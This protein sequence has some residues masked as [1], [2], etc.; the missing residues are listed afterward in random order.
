MEIHP[1]FTE[2]WEEWETSTESFIS[3]DLPQWQGF[4]KESRG[5]LR[6]AGKASVKILV[7]SKWIFIFYVCTMIDN[8]MMCMYIYIY[9][10]FFQ[11]ARY[12]IN[13]FHA[14][15]RGMKRPE[16]L[17]KKKRQMDDK[18]YKQP[19]FGPPVGFQKHHLL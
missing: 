7:L 19:P 15:N 10:C 18:C 8:V 4:L 14:R 5:S 1:L 9:I 11:Y 13:V 12:N 6:N 2:P 17:K 3:I 16:A